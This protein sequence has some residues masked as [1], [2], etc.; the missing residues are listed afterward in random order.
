VRVDPEGL[1]GPTR[2]QARGPDWRRT[3]QGLHVPASVERTV[4]QRIV[5][6]AAVLRT[7]EAVT[8]W[9][10]LRWLGGAWFG[11]TGSL[12]EEYDV[13]LLARR[14]R[15][16]PPGAVVSQEFLHPDQIVVVDTV[17]ATIAV[18][19]V[20]HEMRYAATLGG[21]VAALDMACY[22]DL[23]SI[24]EVAAYVAA[25]GPVTGIQQAR[26]AIPLADENSWSP[27]ETKMRGV[28]RSVDLG[29]SLC[30]RPVFTSDGR[31]IGT[32]DL[33]HPELGL[34][35]Q[36]NGSD[37]ISLAGTANDVKKD[38]AYRDAGLETVTML[39]TDWSDLEDYTARLRAAA[40]RAAAG[41]A[42]RSWTLEQPA[43]WS[44][45]HTVAL[46]RAL[47]QRQRELYLRYR[48]VA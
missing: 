11:G 44:P 9:A 10:G 37:H 35:G 42:I 14:D 36:Y 32:P 28:W 43:W 39:V 2:G 21:A 13:P 41:T 26:D 29:K 48:R 4:D 30:N 12:G 5:E 47:D 25:L 7:D 8:G 3:S 19:S 22:S 27:R 46:R 20:V 34:V 17:P 45:T 6:A 23:V 31:H 15:A 18:R 24:A 33:I 40:R 16:A 1:T 38:A